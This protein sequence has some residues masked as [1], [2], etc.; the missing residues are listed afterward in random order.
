[1]EMDDATQ[2]KLAS[3]FRHLWD[4]YCDNSAVDVEELLLN[5]DF[6]EEAEATE[7]DVNDGD[8]PEGVDVG[9]TYIRLTALG[10]EVFAKGV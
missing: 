1:M 7:E 3:L 2:L 6:A 5:T 8:T 4:A 10:H 9:D